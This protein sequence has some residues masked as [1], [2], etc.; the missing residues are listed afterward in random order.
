M[1]LRKF[2]RPVFKKTTKLC[3]S[4]VCFLTSSV[5]YFFSPDNMSAFV[6][7]GEYPH[8][9]DPSTS[10]VQFTGVQLNI[11]N[12]YN[13]ATG[14]FTCVYPG[15]YVFSLNLYKI[16]QHSKVY[17]HIRKNGSNL[18]IADVPSETTKAGEYESSAST[19][20]HLSRGDKIDVGDCNNVN[21]IDSWTSFTGFL[22]KA[23]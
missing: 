23:D 1:C 11:G 12:H 7:Y 10:A 19:I 6:I 18:V 14:Q 20:T 21:S 9:V 2:H 13:T 8:S 3:C 16:S 17:C 22:L 5:R 15:L 4:A